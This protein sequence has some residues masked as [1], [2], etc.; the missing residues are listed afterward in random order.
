[1]HTNCQSKLFPHSLPRFSLTKS[2]PQ[3]RLPPHNVHVTLPLPIQV[4]IHELQIEPPEHLRQGQVDLHHS[5]TTPHRVTNPVSKRSSYMTSS[6]GRCT[7]LERQDGNGVPTYLRP[8]HP[9]GPKEK[10][11]LASLKLAPSPRPSIHRSG[12][13]SMGSGK[14][15]SSCVTVHALVYISA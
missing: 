9:L 6:W 5:K 14:L 13:N 11:W 1:M 10:G 15:R 4:L 12:L 7:L 3:V 2:N 8:R